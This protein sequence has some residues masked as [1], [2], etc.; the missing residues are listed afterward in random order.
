MFLVTPDR[1]GKDRLFLV[2][3]GKEG[4]DRVFVLISYRE[5][6]DRLYLS[7]VERAKIE[8]RND[9]IQVHLGAQGVYWGFRGAQLKGH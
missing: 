7:W 3:P 8:Q 5:A 2:T 9:S 6:K 4:K 1:E